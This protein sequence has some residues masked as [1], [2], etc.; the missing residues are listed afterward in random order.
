MPASNRSMS[1]RYGALQYELRGKRKL[2]SK[3]SARTISYFAHRSQR[4]SGHE[5]DVALKMKTIEYSTGASSNRSSTPFRPGTKP[6]SIAILPDHPTP[7][8]LAPHVE[9]DP[10]HDLPDERTGRRGAGVRRIRSSERQLWRPF[11]RSVHGTIHFKKIVR[12]A[13]SGP[14]VKAKTMKY[15]STNHTAP[16]VTLGEAVVRG[17]APD[18][19]SCPNKLKNVCPFVLRWNRIIHVVPRD[20]LP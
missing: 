5:G 3:R 13:A 1:K 15:Y 16:E 2:P 7:C 4:R 17:L 19:D 14:S 9:T 6:V 12:K 11:G 18:K 8:A 20:R 10:V